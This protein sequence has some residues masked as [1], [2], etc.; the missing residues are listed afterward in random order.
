M[1]PNVIN[2]LNECIPDYCKEPIEIICLLYYI[3]STY[4]LKFKDLVIFFS[5]IVLV[6]T[7]FALM[8]FIAE[9][10]LQ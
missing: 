5:T 9:A 1:S 8:F 10:R 7:I 4:F 3:L 6:I 2:F